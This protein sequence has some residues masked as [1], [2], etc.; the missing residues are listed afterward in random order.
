MNYTKTIGF[1]LVLAV[2]PAYTIVHADVNE[3]Q[4]RAAANDFYEGLRAIF[5][6]DTDPMENVWSHADDITYMGPGGDM[7]T[8]WAEVRAS[9]QALAHLKI[10]GQ[11]T[12]S[13]LHVILGNDLAIVQNNEYGSGHTMDGKALPSFTIRATNVFRKENGEWKMISHHT[14]LFPNAED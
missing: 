10:G 2:L 8:G 14:D 3:Q 9:W 4:V 13:E 6:G 5:V 12:T 11:V 7:L 1:L